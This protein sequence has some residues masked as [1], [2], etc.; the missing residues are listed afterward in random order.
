MGEEKTN[1]GRRL[2][3]F[4]NQFLRLTQ[5]EFAARMGTTQANISQIENG[6]CLPSGNYIEQLVKT[7]PE[8]NLNW[9]FSG[10]GKM[11]LSTQDDSPIVQPELKKCEAEVRELKERIFSLMDSNNTLIALLAKSK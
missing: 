4:R 5:K 11:I 8:L 6:L 7:Y 3:I 2:A 9:V 10:I 1:V